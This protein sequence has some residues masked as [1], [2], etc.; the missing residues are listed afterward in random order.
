MPNRRQSVKKSTKN[1]RQKS[2]R[3]NRKRVQKSKKR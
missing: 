3:V 1:I 2:R